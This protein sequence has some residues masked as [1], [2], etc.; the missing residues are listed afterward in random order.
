MDGQDDITLHSRTANK[1]LSWLAQPGKS[2]MGNMWGSEG[3]FWKSLEL[4]C[5][6]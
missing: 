3:S 2:A 4:N 5:Q 6:A 1:E